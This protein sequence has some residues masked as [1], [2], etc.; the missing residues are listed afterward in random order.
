MIDYLTI[1]ETYL[2]LRNWRDALGDATMRELTVSAFDA[3]DA[4]ARA[5]LHWRAKGYYV[6]SCEARK[7]PAMSDS[8]KDA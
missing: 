2:P 1:A 5:I 3:A 6:K 7:V 4:K 8:A